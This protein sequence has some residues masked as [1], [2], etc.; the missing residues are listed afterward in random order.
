[1]EDEDEQT[2]RKLA[3]DKKKKSNDPG[4]KFAY[5][6]YPDTINR[7]KQHKIGIFGDTV[8]CQKITKKIAKEMYDYVKSKK[9]SKFAQ[10]E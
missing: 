5:F 6:P 3:K 4:L 9:K 8:K 10:Q 2:N 7:F 1:M